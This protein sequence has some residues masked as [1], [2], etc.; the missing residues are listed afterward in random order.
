MANVNDVLQVTATMKVGVSVTIQNVY[1][2]VVK[3]IG[4][5]DDEDVADDMGEYLEDIYTNLVASMT[6]S[7]IFIDYRVQNLTTEQ[8]IGTFPWPSLTVGSSV[9]SRLPFGVAALIKAK[10]QQGKHQGRK[11]FAL[12]TEDHTDN[13]FVTAALQADLA[14]AGQAAY[15]EFTSTLVN[16]YTP[17]VLER[18]VLGGRAVLSVQVPADWSYQRRRKPG[19]G[20]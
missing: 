16:N 10:T 2:L 5:V 19:V 1:H 13:G 4:G 20:I 12:F 11:Y 18:D 17:V 7:L 3:D 6:S 14:D 15:S 9:A 8:D